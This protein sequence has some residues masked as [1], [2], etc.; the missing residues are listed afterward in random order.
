M[1]GD[2]RTQGHKTGV[3]KVESQIAGSQGVEYS[4]CDLLGYDAVL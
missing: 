2:F 3:K 1:G 4:D